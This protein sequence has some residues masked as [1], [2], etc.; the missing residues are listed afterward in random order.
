MAKALVGY[1]GGPVR[2]QDIMVA[3]LRR[4]V[5]DLEAEVA[6]LKNEND[7]LVQALSARVGD[8]PSVLLEAAH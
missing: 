2:D 6:R 3:R 5:T 4:R 7:G 8:D 1:I